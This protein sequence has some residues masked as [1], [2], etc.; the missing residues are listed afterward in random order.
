MAEHG[1]QAPDSSQ[2]SAPSFDK[3]PTAAPNATPT[4]TPLPSPPDSAER[5]R[6]AAVALPQVLAK[7]LSEL[8]ARPFDLN[9]DYH[10]TFP[11]SWEEFKCARE[12]I[13]ATFRRFDYN[14]F[15]GEITI[16][17]PSFVHDSFAG[18]FNTAVLAKLLP[19]MDGDTDTAKFVASIRSILSVD[20]S[21]DYQRQ[22]A[23]LGDDVDK[24]EQKSP[25]LQYCHLESEHSGVVIEVAYSQQGKELKKLAKAYIGGSKG[26]IKAVI[27]FDINKDKESTISV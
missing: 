11:L 22:P 19:L 12:E 15:K 23:N 14:P 8:E 4:E 16:R 21:L 25:D 9:E 10:K 3:S 18:S 1:K 7:V 26:G 17:M 27:G 5:A 6:V 2:P 20:I 13:E 24:K